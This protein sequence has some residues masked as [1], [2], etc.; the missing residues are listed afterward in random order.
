MIA[1]IAA[2]VLAGASPPPLSDLADRGLPDY[3]TCARQAVLY[4]RHALRL[5]GLRAGRG[6]EG[7]RYAAWIAESERYAELWELLC[8]SWS[9][10]HAAPWGPF[11][12]HTEYELPHRLALQEYRRLVG[13]RLYYAGWTPPQLQEPTPAVMPRAAEANNANP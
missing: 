12:G 4:R 13:V 5:A 11:G 2:A 7:G 9:L 1:L 6:S 8:L 10:E 3:A